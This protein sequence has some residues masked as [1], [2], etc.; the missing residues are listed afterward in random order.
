MD[1]TVSTGIFQYLPRHGF[2][3]FHEHLSLEK[4]KHLNQTSIF[5]LKNVS[6]RKG[7]RN[8]SGCQEARK[9]IPPFR[10][11]AFYTTVSR[12]GLLRTTVTVG[13][14]W[15]KNHGVEAGGPL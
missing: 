3:G 1:S 15:E 14:P 8:F 2:H 5:G 7:V 6:F 13:K 11:P 10:S 12:L 4:E 9:G